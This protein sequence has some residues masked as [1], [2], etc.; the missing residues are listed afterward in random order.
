MKKC[1]NAS[2]TCGFRVVN[3]SEGMGE[4]YGRLSAKDKAKKQSAYLV[5]GGRLVKTFL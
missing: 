1:V 4:M 3:L 2:E 5:L